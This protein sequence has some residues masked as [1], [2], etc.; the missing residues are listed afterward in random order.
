M[1][2]WGGGGESEPPA[3]R[4][5]VPIRIR[6]TR[7]RARTERPGRREGSDPSTAGVRAQILSDGGCESVKRLFR[8][9]KRRRKPAVP[10][11]AWIASD[12]FLASYAWRQVRYQALEA[13]DARCECCGRSKHDLP[14]GEYLNVDHIKN[15][16]DFPELA[17]EISNLE[18][19]CH[20]CNHGRSNGSTRD[21]RHP[22]HPHRRT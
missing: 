5:G 10:N 3:L 14:P 13:N 18:T 6:A 20:P 17:L 15:R 2:G 11:A 8:R 22:K 19:L 21:W 9:F 1:S 12:A 7:C 4:T 16:R